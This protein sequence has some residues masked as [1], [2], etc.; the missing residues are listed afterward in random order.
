[1]FIHLSSH[2]Q[3][4]IKHN[5]N[6]YINRHWKTQKILSYFENGQL[7]LKM[8]VKN[9]FYHRIGAP[10]VIAYLKNGLPTPLVFSPFKK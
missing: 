3:P 2:K 10:A 7:E 6:I 9:G 4:S 1:M 5:N 8:W